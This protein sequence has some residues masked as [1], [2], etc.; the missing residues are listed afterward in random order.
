MPRTFL[1]MVG[2]IYTTSFSYKDRLPNQ[3]S[4][5]HMERRAQS[6]PSIVLSTLSDWVWDLYNLLLPL[7]QP[8]YP[9]ANK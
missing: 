7:R 9:G 2:T 6:Q 5:P 4:S 8:I 3:Q 1:F